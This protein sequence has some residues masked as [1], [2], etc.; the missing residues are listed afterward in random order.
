MFLVLVSTRWLSP[1]LGGEGG[2]RTSGA[3]LSLSQTPKSY[4]MVLMITPNK[5]VNSFCTADFS[6]FSESI[7]CVIR[8][9][10][11]VCCSSS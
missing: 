2:V 7:S 10:G 4:K 8:P 11:T 3:A 9:R 5:E 1:Q 6:V